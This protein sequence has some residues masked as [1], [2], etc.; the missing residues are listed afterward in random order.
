MRVVI[1]PDSYKGSLSAVDVASCMERGILRACPE[2]QVVKVPMADGGEGTVRALVAATGGT[3][4]YSTVTGPLGERVRAEWGVLGDGATAVVEMAS[5]SGLTLVPHHSRNPYFTTTYGTGEL[6]LEALGASCRKI[7]IGIGGSATNDGGAGMAKA[8]GVK[9]YNKDGLTVKQGGLHLK[10]IASIDCSLL[11]SRV[12][13]TEFVV[14]CDV[15]NPLYGTLGAAAVYGPQKGATPAMVAVLDQGL[16]HYAQC[17]RASV[18]IDISAVPGAG[19]AGG[20]GGGLMAFINAR[21]ERGI[22]II[23]AANGLAQKIA[24]CDLVLTG[25]GKIDSQTA[26][27]KVA[28]GVAGVAR[29]CGVP[30][31]ALC[32]SIDSN[33]WALSGGEFSAIFSS[34]PGPIALTEAIEQAERLLTEASANVMRT[35]MTGYAMG[36]RNKRVDAN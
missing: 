21:L 7:I 5:A 22:D 16:R 34:Y 3:L 31:I 9:F 8:L 12:R 23:M 15:D 19:A 4:R 13:H 17:I 2:A 26:Y 10:D 30:I 24:S 27:G 28:W 20:L 18:G 33:A 29:E 6:I 32:G 25:E 36:G 35:L 14:A 1:A 11:D